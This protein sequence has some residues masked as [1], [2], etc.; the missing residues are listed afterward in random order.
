MCKHQQL[1]D[2]RDAVVPP[3]GLWTYPLQSIG[4]KQENSA[5]TIR[6]RK[7]LLLLICML[8]ITSCS[9][10]E[11]SVSALR[12]LKMY[13]RT[14]MGHFRLTELALYILNNVMVL[15]VDI[16]AGQHPRYIVVS[17]SRMLRACANNIVSPKPCLYIPLKLA[18]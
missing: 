4:F 15:D 11:C 1:F 7:N 16:F 13:L 3:R 8:P 2:S 10:C 5:Y 12:R 18:L 6:C 17:I 14:T 9:E